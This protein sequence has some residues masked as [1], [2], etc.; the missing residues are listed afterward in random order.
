MPYQELLSNNSDS[1]NVVNEFM[2][3]IIRQCV[4]LMLGRRKVI[5]IDRPC[6]G[7]LPALK[8]KSGCNSVLHSGL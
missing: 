7:W 3:D 4:I 6:V 2:V 1:E 5:G 8:K